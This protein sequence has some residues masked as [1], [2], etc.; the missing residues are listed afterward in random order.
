MLLVAEGLRALNS[1][2][3]GFAKLILA[4]SGNR[5]AASITFCHAFVHD[6]KANQAVLGHVF[7]PERVWRV[8][9]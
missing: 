9:S 6:C 7:L 8:D 4:G 2:G 1:H 3:P 5:V